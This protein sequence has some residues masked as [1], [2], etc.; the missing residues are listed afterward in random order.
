MNA[1]F[2]LSQKHLATIR[3]IYAKYPEIKKVLVYGSRAL[4]TYRAG[5]DIDMTIISDKPFPEERLMSV[6]SDFDDSNLPFLIDISGFSSL[7]NKDLI[8]HIARFGKVI[9]ER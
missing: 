3:A 8:D 2:G 7:S 9:Y 6:M 5:S 4:G 1:P